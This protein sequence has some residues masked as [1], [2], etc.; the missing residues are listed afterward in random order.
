[1]I[2]TRAIHIRSNYVVRVGHARLG[3]VRLAGI[4]EVTLDYVTVD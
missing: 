1:M 3:H 2:S 4:M